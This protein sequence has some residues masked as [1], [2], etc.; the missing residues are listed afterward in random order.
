MEAG[1]VGPWKK[2]LRVDVKCLCIFL[3]RAIDLKLHN[4]QTGGV[5]PQ[6]DRL[7]FMDNSIVQRKSVQ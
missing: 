3:A 6:M 5:R 7:Y 4:G 1:T 2:Q